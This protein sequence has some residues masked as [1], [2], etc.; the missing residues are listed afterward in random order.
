MKP[1]NVPDAADTETTAAAK[2]NAQKD[3]S[4]EQYTRHANILVVDDLELNRELIASFLKT[5]GY[6]NISFA[7]NGR[8]AI[9]KIAEV[10]P[11]ILILDLMMPEMDGFA[12]CHHL[13]A[14]EKYRDLPILIQTAM[15][16]PA[17]R[18]RAFEAGAT[19]LVT[20][21]ITPMELRARVKIHLQNRFLLKDLRQYQQRLSK[22][23]DI[24]RNMQSA[25]LPTGE[26][27]AILKETHGLDLASMYES[28]DELGGDFW[29]MQVLNEHQLFVYITDFAGHGVSA[30]LNTFRLHS[31][32]SQHHQTIC[33]ADYLAE[34]NKKLHA[35][36][37]V[38]QYATMF[39]AVI[40]RQAQQISYA[41]AASTVPLLCYPE[42]GDVKLLNPE[43]FP[44]GMIAEATYDLHVEPFREN[45]IL[46]LYSDVLT[47]ATNTDGE[48]LD[49]DGLV[50]ILSGAL[51]G[52]TTN[53]DFLARIMA[54][55][56][57]HA[58]RPLEDDL[59]VVSLH[60]IS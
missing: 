43:G 54:K 36:L 30:A 42:T 52:F 37:P 14:D 58:I 9:D 29:G 22:D 6:E 1:E 39:C 12:V 45:D 26:H 19:D 44:L 8:D 34:L 48:M 28:S 25:L 4:L 7:V 2:D 23:L 15:S 55:Y 56:D 24:A 17:E 38:E 50:S 35:L 20:K 57:K 47:E 53:Q 32:I 46:F 11:D 33:P 18:A 5:D 27:M 13:R 16:E 40:D 59:T 60:K 10:D 51:D 3:H 31:L 41:S 21:P 49:T